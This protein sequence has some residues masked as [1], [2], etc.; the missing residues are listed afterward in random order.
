[1]GSIN[2]M[3]KLFFFVFIISNLIY[4]CPYCAGQSGENYI[5]EIIIPI[6]GLL[7]SPFIIIGTVGYII[8]NNKNK[9]K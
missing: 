1:M 7:L 5:Q 2:L 9:I 6:T 4:S 8:Y 3:S